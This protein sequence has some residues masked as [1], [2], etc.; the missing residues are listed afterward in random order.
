M[1]ILA[2]IYVTEAVA[3]LGIDTGLLLLAMFLSLSA[4]GV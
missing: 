4:I 3:A 1:F 2:N